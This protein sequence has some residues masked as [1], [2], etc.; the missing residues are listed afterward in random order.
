MNIQE[1]NLKLRDILENWDPLGYGEGAYEIEIVDCIQAVHNCT[2][3]SLLTKKIQDI[4]EFSFEEIIPLDKCR[5]KA[6]QLI[7]IAQQVSCE[8]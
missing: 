4:Y 6:A 1:M 7:N 3:L 8:L 5:E 2:G